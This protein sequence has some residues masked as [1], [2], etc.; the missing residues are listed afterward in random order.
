D[1]AYFRPADVEMLV[2]DASKA[3]RL[4]AWTPAIKFDQLVEIMMQA[5][6]EA[7]GAV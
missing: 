5:D 6:L 4:L 1:P 7:A 3:K 2:G